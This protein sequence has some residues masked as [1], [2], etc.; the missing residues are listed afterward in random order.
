M[1]VA[2]TDAA[3]FWP[4]PLTP[5]T[6][7][8]VGAWLV[9]LGVLSA[10]AGFQRDIARLYPIFFPA[11]TFFAILHGIALIRFHDEL[12]WARPSAWLYV[13][14]LAG[15]FGVGLYNWI[16][17]RYPNRAATAKLERSFSGNK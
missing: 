3:A 11:M 10:H 12:D 1:I 14:A 9:A 16:S 17:F 4:W 7:R 13:L 8:A 5:L 15:W 6:G 2:P